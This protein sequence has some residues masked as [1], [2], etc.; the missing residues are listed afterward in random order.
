MAMAETQPETQKSNKKIPVASGL[1]FLGNTL[2]IAKDPGKFFVR[3]YRDYG[4]VCRI[5]VFGREQ[6]LLSGPESA[7]MLSTRLG[8]EKLRSKEFWDEFVKFN[9]AS[10]QLNSVE[11]ETHRAL[12]EV[13]RA[14]FSR[15]AV[16]G[17]YH[18][19]AEITDDAL[20]RDWP[21]GRNVP[22]VEAFQFMIVQQLGEIM[23]GDAP[24]AYVRDIRMNILYLLNVLVT[25]QRPKFFLNFP[26][27][28]KA[29]AR[30]RE[31]SNQMVINFKDMAAKD[32]LPNN[33]L[34]DVMRA[35]KLDPE[36]IPESDL[37]ILLT[38]PYVAGLDTVAN[39]IASTVY[40]ILKTPGVLEKVQ[41]EADALFE[42][43]SITED[44]VRGLDYINACVKESMRLWPI[45]VAGMRVANEEFEW[46][47][48]TIP[49]DELLFIGLTVPHHMEEY[50][51]EPEKFDPYR[52]YPDRKEH[53]KP[54]AY[55]PFSRGTHT[56]L[57]QQ[58]AE[59]QMGLTMAR[60]FHRFNLE[61]QS[62]NYVLKTKSAPTPGPSM[63][64]RVKVVSERRPAKKLNPEQL[65]AAE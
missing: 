29:N 18:R 47:G 43:E 8:K 33:L 36:L 52:F 58:L 48:F 38:G 5:K 45:A 22:V 51:P 14:G 50:F 61:L 57:G 60:L 15:D 30:F 9:G 27:F 25:R 56:C 37:H 26:E 10:K 1:P 3:C 42:N 34:G 32:A 65:A 35:H 21:V 4:P 2:E 17:N 19:L 46:E 11:G 16:A 6:I 24:M 28:K 31:L 20:E 39:T 63:D 55:S 40:A 49:E 44:D 12:R 54:G 23:T 53:M 59:V 13:M 7:I 41:A 64:F 62:P